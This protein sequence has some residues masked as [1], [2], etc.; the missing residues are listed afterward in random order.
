[1]TVDMSLKMHTRVELYKRMA[2]VVKLLV[3][4]DI[5]GTHKNILPTH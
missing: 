3:M 1:M 4:H 2:V 5:Q